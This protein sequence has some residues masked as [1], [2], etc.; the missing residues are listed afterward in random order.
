MKNTTSTESRPSPL[1]TKE[2]HDFRDKLINSF[3]ATEMAVSTIKTAEGTY[4]SEAIRLSKKEA[5][6]P[7]LHLVTALLLADRIVDEHARKK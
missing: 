5:A 2:I 7:L 1:T 3:L 4:A 6:A